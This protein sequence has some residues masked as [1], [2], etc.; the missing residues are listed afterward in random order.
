MFPQKK[1][2]KLISLVDFVN[3]VYFFNLSW[4]IKRSPDGI[5]GTRMNVS[6][7]NNS[8]NALNGVMDT[9]NLYK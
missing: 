5:S 1:M 7:Q 6:Q 2:Y 3:L 9:V 8:N 4:Y